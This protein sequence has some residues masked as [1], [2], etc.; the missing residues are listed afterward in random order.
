[1]TPTAVDT[2]VNASQIA[3]MLRPRLLR[4]SARAL[5]SIS[6]PILLRNARQL[7]CSS[8]WRQQTLTMED[9]P[10]SQ[11]PG[12]DPSKLEVTKTITPKQLVP[13]EDL[14][15]GRTFTGMRVALKEPPKYA[16]EEGRV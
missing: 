3:S 10:T 1:M 7:S 4:S 12:I 15:F 9:D 2:L 16:Q 5:T 8:S 6:R 14:I 11:L 13:N